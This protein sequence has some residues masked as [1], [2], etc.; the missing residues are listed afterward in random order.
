MA[1]YDKGEKGFLFSIK[2]RRNK[3]S[4]ERILGEVALKS[5]VCLYRLSSFSIIPITGGGD[6]R[7]H[8]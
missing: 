3:V 2:D 8:P 1:G 5:Y 7:V 4:M 6:E